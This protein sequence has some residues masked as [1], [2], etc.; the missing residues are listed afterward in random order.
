MHRLFVAAQLVPRLVRCQPEWDGYNSRYNLE[1]N[2]IGQA[3]QVQ[4]LRFF[5]FFWLS[6]RRNS[7][8]GKEMNPTIL[9]RVLAV[10]LL[11]YR[12]LSCLSALSGF[13]IR[14]L[15]R[16]ARSRTIDLS[17]DSSVGPL[18]VLYLPLAMIALSSGPKMQILMV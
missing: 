12:P 2:S 9:R 6:C 5:F 15:I 13:S 3:G 18:L 11:Y 16:T 4:V 1:Y 8:H 14:T 10:I 17:V 7:S